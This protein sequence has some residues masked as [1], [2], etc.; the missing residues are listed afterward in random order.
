MDYYLKVYDPVHMK[1][2]DYKQEI[3]YYTC[4]GKVWISVS[5]KMATE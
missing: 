4:K 5:H 3:W 1:D 2:E